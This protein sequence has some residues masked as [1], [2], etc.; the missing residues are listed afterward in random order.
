MKKLLG[1]LTPRKRRPAPDSEGGAAAKGGGEFHEA[2]QVRVVEARGLK[3]MDALGSADPYVSLRLGGSRQ[4]TKVVKGSTEPVWSE[5]FEF[6]GA[7]EAWVLTA[8]VFDWDR[9]SRDDPMGQVRIP[10]LEMGAVEDWYALE[11]MK[12][13]EEP[14]GELRLCCDAV[15]PMGSE[16]RIKVMMHRKAQQAAQ[17]L[18]EAAAARA[19]TAIQEEVTGL[20]DAEA[21][22]VRE[23]EE[24]RLAEQRADAEEEEARLAEEAAARELAEAA[25]AQ[26]EAARQQEEARLAEE[27][28]LAEERDVR[29]AEEQLEAA[30]ASGDAGRILEAKKAL[31]KEQAEA[32]LAKE[33]ERREREEAEEARQTALKEQAQAE[34]AQAL[35]EKER[36]EADSAK[37]VAERERAEADEAR[38]AAE[39]EAIEGAAAARLE[40]DRA[41]M[42]AKMEQ[43]VP[44]GRPEVGGGEND[45]GHRVFRGRK[46][47]ALNSN[48]FGAAQ[49]R[50]P[51]GLFR[52]LQP[53][54]YCGRAMPGGPIEE[55]ERAFE[56]AE[57][58]AEA[59]YDEQRAELLAGSQDDAVPAIA[60]PVTVGPS[61]GPSATVSTPGVVQAKVLGAEAD[62]YELA[63][64]T[65]GGTVTVERLDGGG[66][67]GDLRLDVTID[68]LARLENA[69]QQ[70][71]REARAWYRK[72]KKA[73]R[74][75]A[76]RE[77]K[78]GVAVPGLNGLCGPIDGEQCPSCFRYQQTLERDASFTVWRD[79]WTGRETLRSERQGRAKT[80]SAAEL[81]PLQRRRPAPRSKRAQRASF[82][83][84]RREKLKD[85]LEKVQVMVD[86]LQQLSGNVCKRT[87]NTLQGSAWRYRW[88][89][90]V[91]LPQ[92]RQRK[93]LPQKFGTVLQR[94]RP[95]LALEY[96]QHNSSGRVLGQVRLAGTSDTGHKLVLECGPHGDRELDLRAKHISRK[97]VAY[98]PHPGFVV[99]G[100]PPENRAEPAVFSAA[101]SS[102]EDCRR[103]RL[104][105]KHLTALTRLGEDPAKVQQAENDADSAS[106]NKY[107]DA[108]FVES[109]DDSSS[110]KY[111]DASFEDEHKPYTGPTY[112]VICRVVECRGLPSKEMW[113]KND[114]FVSIA[115]SAAG[116]SDV[117][118]DGEDAK[119]DRGKRHRTTTCEEGGDSPSWG[120]LGGG[121][122]FL[123]RG[124]A[125][126]WV[127]HDPPSGD[128]RVE[129]LD[130]D[131]AGDD[132]LI[133]SV[134]VPLN[135]I[136]PEPD[137]PEGSWLE[138]SA[139]GQPAGEVRL[140]VSVVRHAG[141][142]G[143]VGVAKIKAA[144]ARAKV[145]AVAG[146]ASAPA[147]S[148]AAIAAKKAKAAALLEEWREAARL[149]EEK[150]KAVERAMEAIAPDVKRDPA[151]FA[152]GH[153][154][155]Y[156]PP[157]RT[158]Y[159]AQSY[160]RDARNNLQG[161]EQFEG[162]GAASGTHVRYFSG[163]L[164][165]M[166]D[167]ALEQQVAA[168]A[169]MWGSAAV[170][171]ASSAQKEQRISRQL[172]RLRDPY[173]EDE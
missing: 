74:A 13:C 5:E 61:D 149:R 143:G 59:A 124:Y 137:D 156:Q 150:A 119:D 32:E 172:V 40:A 161:S 169:R 11:P 146:I 56:A 152:E 108:S 10:A 43:E 44:S 134:D 38:A 16:A 9:F 25:A 63:V 18:R 160:V 79:S 120:G 171:T 94:P 64:D 75:E 69:E 62:A 158:L 2:V 126:E 39:Q 67:A 125:L 76:V 50:G 157:P 48:R 60:E 116:S 117:S 144:S 78:R 45:E 129:V 154:T 3:K 65:A 133:G 148:A 173:P 37:A 142:A 166:V 17:R 53:R 96:R 141:A 84:G 123:D 145:A 7:D 6:Q 121:G 35:A 165:L 80:Y 4:K 58:S 73:L 99:C 70:R 29:L 21:A 71:K 95:R 131:V 26:E 118:D 132:D 55:T 170:E 57:E 162:G 100:E 47:G 97:S 105:H 87:E 36:R 19:E 104:W 81:T 164:R 46:S 122:A 68:L 30:Q 167:E 88:L 20:S 135:R 103:A 138:L 42:L 12:G 90:L 91:E 93:G 52:H 89:E 151:G 85:P 102:A 114:V 139:D 72:R 31:A 113:G 23:E 28:R 130:E 155:F 98:A 83:L 110:D 115:L 153:P 77:W 34:A 27:K 54:Y 8:E 86:K 127:L 51:D 128:L 111:S 140:A 92:S 112:Q 22:A 33:D 109:D 82:A 163:E 159:A 15:F 106:D 107:S 136:G 49:V 1:S 168:G 101:S 14:A 41:K 24:A 147:K 66:W